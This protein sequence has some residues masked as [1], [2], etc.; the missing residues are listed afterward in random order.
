AG[1][2]E[3]RSQRER[4]EPLPVRRDAA[5][6]RRGQD[7]AGDAVHRLA[8]GADEPGRGGPDLEGG[9][10]GESVREKCAERETLAGDEAVGTAL[11]WGESRQCVGAEKRSRRAELEPW[12]RS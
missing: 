4:A 9:E 1:G 11:D 3:A 5:P 2:I 8:E 12:S 7:R 10:A 6:G